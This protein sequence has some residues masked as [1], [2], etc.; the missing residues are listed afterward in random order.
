MPATSD[1][2]RE[3]FAAANQIDMITMSEGRR[4]VDRAASTIKDQRERLAEMGKI[5]PVTR[6]VTADLPG[7]LA[8]FDLMPPQLVSVT[9]MKCADEIVRLGRLLGEH[10]TC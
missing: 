1:F 4:L 10:E 5:L 2:V 8:C 6:D 3:L 9:L 7:F